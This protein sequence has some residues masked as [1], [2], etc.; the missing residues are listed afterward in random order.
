MV[1]IPWRGGSVN[2][3]SRFYRI[4]AH[5]LCVAWQIV[6]LCSCGC[7]LII[8]CASELFAG[9]FSR[10][11]LAASMLLIGLEVVFQLDAHL[12]LF[13]HGGGIF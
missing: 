13:H 5:L 1:F 7:G 9:V 10:K 8:F 11:Q 6:L 2:S 3:S 4:L 12:P